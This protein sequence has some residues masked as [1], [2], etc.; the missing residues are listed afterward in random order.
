[1]DLIKR[2]TADESGAT[3][4]EYGLIAALVGVG[5]IVGMEN[6]ATNQDSAWNGLADKVTNTIN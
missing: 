6:F 5:A 2:F 1:M 4:V 3:A